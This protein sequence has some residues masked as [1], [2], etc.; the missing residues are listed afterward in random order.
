VAPIVAVAAVKPV[1]DHLHQ[2]LVLAQPL[3]AR[4]APTD[5][6]LGCVLAA[7]LAGE[8]PLPGFDNSAMDGYAVRSAEVA[9]ASP[10]NPVTLPVT[11][12]IPAGDTRAHV[13]AP[14]TVMRIMTGAPIP[15]GRRR[16]RSRRADRRR[17]RSR[18]GARR[19]VPRPASPARG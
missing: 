11:A 19:G 16:H 1:E 14:G 17:H 8:L 4:D 12:D 6:A 5:A 2:V 13:L 18:P 3:A 9:G 10:A 7:D 15:R